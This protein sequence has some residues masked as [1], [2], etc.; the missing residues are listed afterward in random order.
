MRTL[1]PAQPSILRIILFL[2]LSGLPAC[3]GFA[4]VDAPTWVQEIGA[5]GGVVVSGPASLHVPGGA[6]EEPLSIEI[7]SLEERVPG[8][9]G[10]SWDLRP[11]D[12][13]F[14]AP[15][16][17]RL[18][19]EPELLLGETSLGDLR[20]ARLGAT[21]QDLEIISSSAAD[22]D[23]GTVR[24]EIARLGVF[25]LVCD[26]RDTCTDD[27]YDDIHG[28]LFEPN[29]CAQ[30]GDRDGDG[31][32]DLDD[33]A[34]DDEA[35]FH[36]AEERCNG[37]DDDCDGET[38]ED[39]QAALCHEGWTCREGLCMPPGCDGPL[40]FADAGL[41]AAVRDALG[42]QKGELAWAEVSD[43]DRLD[44]SERGISALQG[45]A[46]LQALDTLDLSGNDIE[47]I[48]ELA[49][50]PRLWSLNL[51]D[52]RVTDLAPLSVDGGP[53]A[54]AVLKIERNGLDDIAP[55]AELVQLVSL[56]VMEN[57]ISDLSPLGPQ[58]GA[59]VSLFLSGNPIGDL[60]PLIHFPGLLDLT[61][62][63]PLAPPDIGAIE[64]M[65][66]L[67]LLFLYD[68]EL[69]DIDFVTSLPELA[70]LALSGAQEPLDLSPL[71]GLQLANLDIHA[72]GLEDISALA[73]MPGLLT[74]S[75]MENRI[76]DLTPISGLLALKSLNLYDNLV[77]DLGALLD[78]AGIGA[79]DY[80]NLVAN[81]IDC[82]TAAD[83][84]A[85]LRARGVEL[86]T[87]CSE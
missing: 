81:P 18:R 64:A 48:D 74:L 59:L 70:Y 45:L 1:S 37:S 25:C 27:R 5:G 43:L 13:S 46:C 36:G 7:L 39:A 2:F 80:V 73:N 83:K 54:L 86:V 82:I 32:P 58:H 21:G 31:D 20:L 34:P 4:D 47:G 53:Q 55:L 52:N 69:R 87:D 65:P 56:D 71:Q 78:N 3:G 40:D 41:E 19:V 42:I 23:E 84:L 22:L 6:L 9:V 85:E 30:D 33:C 10:L 67:S 76:E 44:A 72:S 79:G 12:L 75:L 8:A 62:T 15:A 16:T 66:G 35:I 61:L 68:C 17:L 29:G 60:S 51:N 24:A 77:V 50:L 26:D 28:C 49:S 63:G 57:A 38:D 11:N 14:G